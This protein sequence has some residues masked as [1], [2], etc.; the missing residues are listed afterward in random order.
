MGTGHSADNNEGGNML[1]RHQE[2]FLQGWRNWSA[3]AFLAAPVSSLPVSGPV[4]AVIGTF[5]ADTASG[6]KGVRA[7]ALAADLFRHRWGFTRCRSNSSL[8]LDALAEELSH[9]E[10]RLGQLH[11]LEEGFRNI[12]AEEETHWPQNGIGRPMTD[13]RNDIQ[14]RLD[15]LGEE[16]SHLET[17]LG[18]LHQWEDGFRN[19]LAEEET[20]WPE[21]GSL[22][23]ANGQQLEEG[24]SP[25]HIIWV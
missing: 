7:G 14:E 13:I 10:T 3:V 18:Q 1:G 6:P 4:G 12:L 9:L 17:R 16:L 2:E 22:L 5:V 24:L 15:A 25:N 8:S 23:N 20:H 11:H 19:I 21:E